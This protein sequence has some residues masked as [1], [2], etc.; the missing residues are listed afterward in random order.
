MKRRKQ[1]T[2][3]IDTNVTKQILGEHNHTK[4]YADIRNFM[5]KERWKH[6]EGSVYMSGGAVENADVF[7][8]IGKL[9]EQYPYLAKCV[10]EMHQTD[11][12]KVHSLNHYFEYDGTPGQYERKQGQKENSDRSSPHHK[13]S[14][15]NKLKQNQ[16]VIKQLE[17]YDEIEKN[18]KTRGQER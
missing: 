15:R 18:H 17:K 7:L 9:K 3:D 12:S 2:F 5:E 13:S 11:V 14:V 10:R 16:E 4:I 1:I 6:V 8:L